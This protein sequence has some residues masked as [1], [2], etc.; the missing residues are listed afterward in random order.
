MG[1]ECCRWIA[2]LLVMA[3]VAFAEG[4]SARISG[5]VF[6]PDGHP[7]A[8][9]VVAHQSCLRSTTSFTAQT[10]PD[11]RFTL[12]VTPGDWVVHA[13]REGFLSEVDTAHL[14]EGQVGGASLRLYPSA[15]LSGTVI[16]GRGRP[17]EGADVDCEDEHGQSL[18]LVQTDADGRYRIAIPRW[19]SRIFIYREGYTTVRTSSD[20]PDGKQVQLDA[21]LL[22]VATVRGRVT[23]PDGG[24]VEEAAVKVRNL[25]Q[26]DPEG[27]LALL[28]WSH[29]DESSRFECTE[30]RPG[31]CAVV[32][33][34]RGYAV[35]TSAEFELGEGEEREVNAT[36]EVGGRI[37]VT[38]LRDLDGSPVA[39]PRLSLVGEPERYVDSLPRGTSVVM[40]PDPG[41]G[42][43]SIRAGPHRVAV[44]A[45]GLL[46][47]VLEVEV[48]NGETTEVECR[49]L[50]GGAI[51]GRV[52]AANGEPVA[53]VD[54]D[55]K[56]QPL[57]QHLSRTKTNA[58]GAYE[59]SG[60]GEG[61]YLVVAWKSQ[62]TGGHYG[63]AESRRCIQ[64]AAQES[65]ELDLP[66]PGG[67]TLVGVLTQG[68]K[69][70]P[71]TPMTL[72]PTTRTWIRRTTTTDAEGRYR[73]PDVAADDYTVIVGS[74]AEPLGVARLSVPSVL[75]PVVR[76]LDLPAG[77]IRGAVT[78]QVSGKALWRTCVVALR[79]DSGRRGFSE[80]LERMAGGT[81]TDAGGLYV[82]KSLP[83]GEYDVVVGAYGRV[84]YFAGQVTVPK[85]G[86]VVPLDVVVPFGVPIDVRATDEAGQDLKAIFELREVSRGIEVSRWF[87]P[88]SNTSEV[89]WIR[90]QGVS[91]GR[92]L[93][94]A[95]A[96]G[97]GLAQREVSVTAEGPLVVRFALPEES[98]VRLTCRDGA[99][100]ALEGAV[101]IMR[102]PD[103]GSAEPPLP[104]TS[105]RPGL[106]VTDDAGRLDRN[107]LTAGRYVGEVRVGAL[108]ARFEVELGPG[109]TKDVDV[110]LR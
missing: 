17:L 96:E 85:G 48:R 38:V 107:G 39:D 68:G 7:C 74:E 10:Q 83:P 12:V 78:D 66:A 69:P 93:I 72:H 55:L 77:R 67:R 92:Y 90:Y 99:G 62:Q 60:L 14:R 108:A 33:D 28:D 45:E 63:M 30:V 104:L 49:L 76:D 23:A 57:L 75:A 3:S 41:E 65:V 27:V 44:G 59:F 91:P 106:S 50:R 64:L 47:R 86:D 42:L 34:A 32:A 84:A 101:L 22:R 51:R 8:A 31:R 36:L 71:L 5:A 89:G 20:S 40:F 58:D 79:A 46:T 56:T 15:T 16:D 103:G 87:Q 52:L 82:I 105:Q 97:H 4:E 98:V 9:F 109:E 18:T 21:Q 43:S 61:T 26:G 70:L 88:D 53:D 54:V 19:R 11:G 100:A 25:A 1:L 29:T 80:W 81:V 94:S 102:T 37:N 95:Y 13:E 73:V 6:G 35:T 24:P 110:T 2:T